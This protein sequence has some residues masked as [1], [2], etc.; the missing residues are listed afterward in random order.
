VKPY[1]PP[2]LWQELTGGGGYQHDKGDALYRRSLY[3]YWRRTIAPPSMVTFDSPTRETCIVRESRTN[4]PLQALNLMNDVAF[5]EAS[6]KL[7]ERMLKEGGPAPGSRVERGFLLAVARPPKAEETEV[8]SR[9]LDRL[10]ARYRRDST[11]AA[12]LLKQGDSPPE[13]SL[14]PVELAA[15]T[16]VASLIL[17]LDE[18]VTKQ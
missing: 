11:A 9:L 6:R 15:Y 12:Q 5:V 16:G 17:N 10:L 2:G 18:T 14:D 4:T 7:A 3:T 13:A 1:Q 8:A